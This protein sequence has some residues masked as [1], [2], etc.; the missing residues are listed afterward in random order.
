MEIQCSLHKPKGEN[1]K[2]KIT[3]L[4]AFALLMAASAFGQDYSKWEVPIDF[5]YARAYPVSV[6]KPFSMN[7]GGGGIVYNFDKYF[8]IKLDLQGYASTTATF[9]NVTVIR[10]G[11]PVTGNFS[12]SGNLFTYIGGPQIRLPGY[13]F[14]P[15]CEVLRGGAHTNLYA[16]LFTNTG[17]LGIAPS[18]NAFALA[19]GG[20]VDIRLTDMISIRPVEF[21]YLLT[22]FGNDAFTGGGRNQNNFRYLAGVTLKFG[23]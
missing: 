9:N 12:A 16:N 6:A 20:G 3:M 14:R 23:H 8:G 10:P 22:H 19:A 15:F 17:A 21:D 13:V 2:I 1:M 4:M 5:T 18:N 7:G 11:G